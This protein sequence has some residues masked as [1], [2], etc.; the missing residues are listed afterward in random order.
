MS[1]KKNHAH[2]LMEKSHQFP[3]RTEMGHVLNGIKTV[4]SQH[5]HFSLLQWSLQGQSTQKSCKKQKCKPT[6]SYLR[7]HSGLKEVPIRSKTKIIPLL[8]YAPKKN[9]HRK[10]WQSQ[11]SHQ[12]ATSF[13]CWCGQTSTL[14][15]RQILKLYDHHPQ[16]RTEKKKQKTKVRPTMS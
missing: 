15:V 2:L 3:P 11:L 10:W 9:L 13:E 7:T 1:G 5:T 6:F 12:D 4:Q 8:S 14:Y 16:K